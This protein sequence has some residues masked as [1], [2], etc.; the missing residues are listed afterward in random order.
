MQS[1]NAGQGPSM[2]DELGM[3]LTIC[4]G[5]HVDYLPATITQLV[6]GG[7]QSNES[8]AQSKIYS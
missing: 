5:L 1:K 4:F 7:I 3:F 6:C 2:F 8:E